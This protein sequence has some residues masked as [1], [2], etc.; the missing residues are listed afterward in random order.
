MFCGELEREL[1][2]IHIG[3]RADGVRQSIARMFTGSTC[4]APFGW[5]GAV[6]AGWRVV[7]V[8]VKRA[9]TNRDITRFLKAVDGQRHGDK[10]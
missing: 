1:I 2:P 5:K 4:S 10:P 6:K 8:L 7:P 3:L 9:T